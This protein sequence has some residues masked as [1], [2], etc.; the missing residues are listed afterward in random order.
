LIGLD[1][2]LFFFCSEAIARYVE[3][4]IYSARCFEHD[5]RWAEDPGPNDACA[6]LE[7]AA[8][9]GAALIGVT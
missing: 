6:Q 3:F 4:S 2:S 1:F 9:I 5:I 7:A 8:G